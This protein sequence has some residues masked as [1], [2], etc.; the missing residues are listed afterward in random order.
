MR[1]L[2]VEDEAPL[3]ELLAERLGAEGW[4][5]DAAG[6]GAE[7][8][9]FLEEAV[10]DAAIVD[11]GLP[12]LDGVDLIRAMRDAGSKTPIIILTARDAWKE[13]V[14]GLNSGADDYLA[15][16]FH[17]EELHARL[18]ALVRRAN[19][20]SSAVVT[21]GPIRADLTAKRVSVDRADVDLTAFEYN[22]LEYL[23]LNA[24][25]VV[26]KMEL[27]DHLY[28]QDFDRDSNVIEVF[29][30]RLRKKLDPDNSLKP[31]QTVRGQGYRFV[32]DRD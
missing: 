19:G 16:P 21:A 27:T 15:K 4:V 9:Y 30:G 1:I 25:K 24:G 3:R 29:V 14:R 8:R 11:L 17:F 26:S 28:A 22:V 5:V 13:K 2:I 10:H 12:D 20:V 23:M 31:I 18:Q 7:G 6:T 32:L